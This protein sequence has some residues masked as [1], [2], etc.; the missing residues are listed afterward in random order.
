MFLILS[1]NNSLF[2]HS[3]SS[4]NTLFFCSNSVNN[5]SAA[6]TSH[7]SVLFSLV[8]SINELLVSSSS[9]LT[10]FNSLS[11]NAILAS[12]LFIVLSFSV[13][14]SHILHFSLFV[15][16]ICFFK[17]SISFCNSL[18]FFSLFRFSSST[19]RIILCILTALYSEYI[20]LSIRNLTTPIVVFKSQFIKVFSYHNIC[21]S[22]NFIYSFIDVL[23]K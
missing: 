14:N 11:N 19:S 9:F 20:I 12:N 2:N 18:I 1:A 23:L 10:L 3:F 13:T 8:F 7:K 5:I 15:D 22:N 4:F 21:I 17:S 16:F 6:S